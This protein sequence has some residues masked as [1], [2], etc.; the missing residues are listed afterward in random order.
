[1]NYSYLLSGITLSEEKMLKNGFKQD[2]NGAFVFKKNLA[3]SLQM[4]V[5]ISGGKLDVDVLDCVVGKRCASFANGHSG[6]ALRA[7]VREIVQR[8]LNDCSSNL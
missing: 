6:S 7:E 2:E 1:M 3:G 4:V 5:K 8:L